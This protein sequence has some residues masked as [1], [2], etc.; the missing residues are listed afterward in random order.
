MAQ[1]TRCA[2]L[3]L[4][5]MCS[6]TLAR[7][8]SNG[9]LPSD[10]VALQI[11]SYAR[12]MATTTDTLDARVRT[13]VGFTTMDSTKVVREADARACT[14]AVAGI[15]VKLNT[16]GRARAIHLIKMSTQG[17]LAFVP[18]LAG[19]FPGSEYNPIFVLTKQ[20]AV[21]DGILAF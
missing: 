16:P 8:Q 10:E 14:N 18:A 13:G 9:C 19:T 12:S 11:L 3:I 5:A 15:N 20:G 6:S 21:R 2:M 1:S 4:V 7:G 17:Y